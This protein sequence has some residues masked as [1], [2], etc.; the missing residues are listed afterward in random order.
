MSNPEM[1]TQNITHPT[2]VSCKSTCYVDTGWPRTWQEP[3]RS[4]LEDGISASGGVT[5]GRPLP[6]LSCALSQ[7]HRSMTWP[8]PSVLWDVVG[9]KVMRAEGAME[10]K[11]HPRVCSFQV[12]KT[13]IVLGSTAFSFLPSSPVSH[14]ISPLTASITGSSGG[15]S[16]LPNC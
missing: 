7:Q 3:D 11:H 8:R 2:L 4:G 10:G 6:C 9:L 14:V 12:S 5:W 13:W 1:K 15:P 16:R